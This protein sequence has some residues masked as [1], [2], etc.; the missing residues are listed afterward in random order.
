MTS[1]LPPHTGAAKPGWWIRPDLSPPPPG[2]R[3][4]ADTREQLPYFEGEPWCGRGTLATGDYSL[5]GFEGRVVIER[6]SLPDLYG[7]VS[8][9]RERFQREFERLAKIPRAIL[10]VEGTYRD[11][12][13]PDPEVVRS[14]MLPTSVEGTVLSWCLRWGVWPIF[15][16]GR[17]QAER[18]VFR[19]LALWYL[20]N[21]EGD[22]L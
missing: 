2:F 6:K 17:R 14:R 15:A 9:G 16:G 20:E 12:I 22:D 21:G 18:L 1:W 3:I 8:S 13:D 10:L 11:I 4:V 7:S 5:R 19:T